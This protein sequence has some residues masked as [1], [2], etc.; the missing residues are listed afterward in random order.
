M[1]VYLLKV[2]APFCK[3]VNEDCCVLMITFWGILKDCGN[4][5]QFFCCSKQ[6][7]TKTGVYQTPLY[8]ST[9]LLAE[10]NDELEVLPWK[11][12]G[13][14]DNLE[15]FGSQVI[16]VTNLSKPERNVTIDMQSYDE[17]W[18]TDLEK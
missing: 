11:Y 10:A 2:C 14:K 5:K 15:G 7:S 18:E 1:K 4:I 12:P 9:L 3:Y 8:F 13:E 17:H 16:S 6:S